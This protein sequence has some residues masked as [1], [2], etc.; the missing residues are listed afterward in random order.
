MSPPDTSRQAFSLAGY[1]KGLPSGPITSRNQCARTSESH[2]VP[3]PRGSNT[4]SSVPAQPAATRRLMDREVPA[5]PERPAGRHRDRDE[6]PRTDAFGDLGRDEEGDRVVRAMRSAPS[7]RTR[8]DAASR[9]SDPIN[10]AAAGPSP[11]REY[12][13]AAPAASGATPGLPERLDP[14]QRGKRRAG[15][16]Y[17]GCR[18]PCDAAVRISHPSVRGPRPNG[19]F[20][21]MSTEPSRIRSTIDRASGAP[22]ASD[23]FSTR[24]TGTPA[25]VR[26]HPS[27]SWRAEA[28]VGE[29]FG[30]VHDRPL[31]TVRHAE[32]H[33][34]RARQ[35]GAARDQRL[36]ERE[37]G[38]G[39]AHH[40]AR[41]A[42]LG[43]EHRVD[44]RNCLP[45]GS[46]GVFTE[47]I[48][49]VEV[50]TRF[51]GDQALVP[52]VLERSPEHHRRRPARAGRRSPSRRTERCGTPSGW[53]RA[54]PDPLVLEREHRLINPARQAA[55][56][57]AP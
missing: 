21:T 19:V 44:A 38:S 55:A 42:H 53:P 32:E 3:G 5:N 15:A 56:R 48:R 6:L 51:G 16:S 2:S 24:V 14:P 41:R 29:A 40:L 10:V 35:G 11:R 4:N 20:T 23:T 13:R 12:V 39:S 33:R 27:P 1:A 36:G 22:S 9:S 7:A 17:A 45:K 25:P 8:F 34:P 47:V 31:V 43:A 57:V 28:E 46:T 49:Q 50:V 54:C 37:A 18:P 26:K 30:Q 52:Q